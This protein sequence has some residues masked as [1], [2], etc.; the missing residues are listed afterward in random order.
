MQGRGCLA[1][2]TIS[3]GHEDSRQ[4]TGFGRE[5]RTVPPRDGVSWAQVH[6]LHL[7]NARAPLAASSSRVVR[8]EETDE[9]LL[10][11]RAPPGKKAPEQNVVVSR[12]LLRETNHP[13]W[14]RCGGGDNTREGQPHRTFI[15]RGHKPIPRCCDLHPILGRCTE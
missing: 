7:G 12:A 11:P 15:L 4:L 3:F 8:T 2:S 5:T 6:H 13:A 1:R 14:V 9:Q 10:A